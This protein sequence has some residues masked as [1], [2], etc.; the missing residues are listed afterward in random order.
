V[1]LLVAFTTGGLVTT[2][3]TSNCIFS[4]LGSIVANLPQSILTS[5]Y[6]W[7]TALYVRMFQA[8]DWAR[9][10]ETGS[11]QMLMVTEPQDDQERFY[12]LGIPFHWGL[13]FLACSIM[14]HWTTGQSLYQI[15]SEGMPSFACENF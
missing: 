7:F 9:F 3:I 14:L 8:R 15:A 2:L 5:C 10:S 11:S 4:T 6:F 12:M 13:L 1:E